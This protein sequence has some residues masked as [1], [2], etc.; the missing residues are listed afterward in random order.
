MSKKTG[1]HPLGAN[2]GLI[3]TTQGDPSAVSKSSSNDGDSK[4]SEDNTN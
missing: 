3:G 1:N 2:K 4:T